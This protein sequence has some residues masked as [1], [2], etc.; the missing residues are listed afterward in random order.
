MNLA[1]KTGWPL[2]PITGSFLLFVAIL[3]RY[4]PSYYFSPKDRINE[5]IVLGVMAIFIGRVFIAKIRKEETIDYIYYIAL[6]YVSPF[7]A[8]ALS[9]FLY[10]NS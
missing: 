10:P 7:L 2:L 8:M 1:K 6:L 9:S 4:A 5:F 3:F